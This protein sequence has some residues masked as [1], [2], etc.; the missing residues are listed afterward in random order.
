VIPLLALLLVAVDIESVKSE[1]DLER[2]SELA[3]ANADK[4]IDAA[5]Q[6]FSGGD[7][8][9]QEQALVEVQELVNV[10]YDA[11]E[12]ANRAPRKSKYYKN[13]EMKVTALLRRLNSFRDQV[14]FESRE[15]VDSVIK[16]VS[17]V[18]DELLA[19]IM[20]KKK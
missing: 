15:A 7:E 9:A 11:L 1:P 5:K 13:A 16:R 3:L 4:Q 12:H 6:A 18:H 10:S 2:R 14:G 17:Y 8:K 20:S 19:A